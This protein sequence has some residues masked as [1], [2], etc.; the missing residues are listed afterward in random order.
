MF[1][2]R[3]EGEGL[4]VAKLKTLR[5]KNITLIQRIFYLEKF[6]DQPLSAAQMALMRSDMDKIRE[7]GLK[8]I[9][10]FAYT[11][12]DYV[13]NT[14]NGQDAPL[15][16]VTQHIGQLKPLFQDNQDVIAFVQAGFIGPWGEWHSSTNGLDTPDNEKKIL[17]ALLDALPASIMVQVRTPYA[18]QQIFQ[19][20]APVTNDIA[21]SA[22]KVARVGHHNDCFMSGGT[23]YG[24]YPNIETD[25]TYVSNE[26]LFVPVGGETCPPTGAYDPNCP[27]GRKEMSR[28]KWTYL[29]LDWYQ[30]TVNAWR[31]SGCF[32]EFQRN[33]GY[34]IALLTSRLKTKAAPNGDYKVDLTFINRGFA[35]MYH[36]K[37]TYLVLKNKASGELHEIKLSA[38]LRRAKPGNTL[39]VEESVK[40][41]GLPKGTYDLYLKIT[42]RSE[43]LKAR[44][45]YTVRLANKDA[46]QAG[47][48]MNDL[49]VAL[50]VG[51]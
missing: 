51:D 23:N 46:W 3:S 40:L 38:D 41:T 34:R 15:A 21:Y 2:V 36:L 18:K 6:R 35:P 19:T 8:C 5:E 4:D 14:N 31:A 20:A 28:L 24:T 45:E 9:L 30:P 39:Q 7:A 44:T 12:I 50:T 17:F 11:G 33:L 26:A 27:E 47:T 48:G 37:N 29:N 13:D 42:D 10:R 1:P 43:K 25:K 32:D 22:E 16:T 49:S